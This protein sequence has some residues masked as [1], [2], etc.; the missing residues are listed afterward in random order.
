MGEDCSVSVSR[1]PTPFLVSDDL[2][3]VKSDPRVA[4]L[5][6]IALSLGGAAG[7]QA[8][9]SYGHTSLERCWD[10]VAGAPVPL[11]F[12]GQGEIKAKSLGT[13]LVVT[14]TLQGAGKGSAPAGDLGVTMSP[15]SAAGKEQCLSGRGWLWASS[16]LSRVF[17][18][19]R[20]RDQLEVLLGFPFGFPVI[21][22]LRHG[23]S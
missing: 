6:A 19:C 12:L 4:Q 8:A 9:A 15:R 5:L 7:Q 20:S 3:Q 16:F 21:P 18:R 13:G 10:P 11:V 17:L 22:R 23:S 14:V 1:S 2:C